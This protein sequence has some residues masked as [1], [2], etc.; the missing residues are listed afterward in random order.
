[1]QRLLG[2]SFEKGLKVCGGQRIKETKIDGP[3]GVGYD[4]SKNAVTEPHRWF[5]GDVSGWLAYKRIE[6]DGGGIPG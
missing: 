3:S 4:L 1:M 5:C 2:E 6:R